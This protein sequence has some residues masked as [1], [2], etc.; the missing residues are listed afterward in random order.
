[1]KKITSLALFA[2]PL[3]LTL[4]S[5]RA[6]PP[7][8]APATPPDQPELALV[9]VD[10]LAHRESAY[11]DFDRLDL[12]FQDVA[13][14]RHWPVKIAAERFAANTPAHELEL[15]VFLQPIRQEIPDEFTFRGW[16]TLTE[17]GTKHDFGVVVYRYRPRPGEMMDDSLDKIFRGAAETAAKKI[18]PILFPDLAKPKS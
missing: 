3:A 9:V 10:T 1:M 16:M 13:K 6:A 4:G 8:A 12:A 11:T 7:A 14:R 15:R 5:A 2:L 18:E 17:H